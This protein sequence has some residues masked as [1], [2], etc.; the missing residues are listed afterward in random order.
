MPKVLSAAVA[1]TLAVSLAGCSRQ[2]TVEVENYPV[3]VAGVNINKEVTQIVSLSP[4][5]TGLVVELNQK[6]KLAGLSNFCALPEDSSELPRC[7]TAQ[8]PDIDKILELS[9]ELVLSSASFTVANLQKLEQNGIRV[10]VL[11]VGTDLASWS[12]TAR[13]LARLLGGEVE[14]GARGDNLVNNFAAKLDWLRAKLE[15]VAPRTALIVV[16]AYDNVVTG[17][18]IESAFFGSLFVT[19]AAADFQNYTVPEER[20]AGIAADVVLYDSRLDVDELRAGSWQ[21]AFLAAG[22]NV[23]SYDG[24]A[25]ERQDTSMFGA[26][27]NLAKT[28]YPDRFAPGAEAEPSSPESSGESSSQ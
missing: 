4:M 18:T 11:P 2:P 8:N 9:P 20:R 22:G 15:G 21:T 5:L 24:A 3:S 16:N 14:G 23:F 12:A 28:L 6:G 19:S 7:G 26:L 27:Y 13:N 10:V 17:G 1:L 25:F